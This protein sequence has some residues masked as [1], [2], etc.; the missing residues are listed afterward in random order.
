ML[1]QPLLMPRVDA[2]AGTPVRLRVRA[3]D[4]AVATRVP[5]DLSI[6]NHLFGRIASVRPEQG[7]FAEIAIDL[8]G[9]ILRARLTRHAVDELGLHAG[10]PVVA[11]IKAAAVERRLLGPAPG[12]R[13][14]PPE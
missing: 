14:G 12:R 8:G 1:G 13:A 7:P 5:E 3:R 4:V 6:R 11:L 10:Q 9:P 2:A